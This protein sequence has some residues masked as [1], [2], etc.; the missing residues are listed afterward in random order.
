MTQ[1]EIRTNLKYYMAKIE[2]GVIT[3]EQG[4]NFFTHEHDGHTLSIIKK[5]RGRQGRIKELILE[6]YTAKQIALRMDCTT[7]NVYKIRT[8][9]LKAAKGD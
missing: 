9:L 2:M 6:G 3:A 8:R 1:E 4:Y 5:A 7:S